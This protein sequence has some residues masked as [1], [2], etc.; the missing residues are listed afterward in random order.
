MWFSRRG[1][2]A[3]HLTIRDLCGGVCVEGHIARVGPFGGRAFTKLDVLHADCL[4]LGHTPRSSPIFRR[5][6]DERAVGED[7]IDH[8]KERDISFEDRCRVLKEAVC[9][10]NVFPAFR[11][12]GAR[13]KETRPREELAPHADRSRK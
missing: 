13:E 11:E 2:A 1:I 10:H 12:R 8:E 9:D 3:L 5:A 7:T 4:R 6:D